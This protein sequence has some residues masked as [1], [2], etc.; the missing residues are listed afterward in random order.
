MNT[1]LR[2]LKMFSVIFT[3]DYWLKETNNEADVEK[4]QQLLETTT[5]AKQ[6]PHAKIG[7]GFLD[8]GPFEKEVS[9]NRI[10]IRTPIE[11]LRISKGNLI[12]VR[13]HRRMDGTNKHH[14]EVDV[15]EDAMKFNSKTSNISPGFMKSFMERYHATVTKYSPTHMMA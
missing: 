7:G 8:D 10:I 15:L 9:G 5:I 2:S 1:I 6:T 4:I 3:R 12:Y 13:K 11:E 14:I